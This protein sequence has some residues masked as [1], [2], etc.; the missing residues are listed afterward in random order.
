LIAVYYFLA[1]ILWCVGA[2]FLLAFSFCSKYRR[3]I[4]ARFFLW[5]N[6][7]FSP[8]KIHF[9]ACSF[10]EV[11]SIAPLV[12]I[13]KENAAISV[14]TQTGFDE[15]CKITPNSRFLPFEIFLPFWMRRSKILIIFEAELWPMLVFW[16]RFKGA[17]VILI[18]ARIS[19]RSYGKYLKFSFF[20]REIFK[21]IDK[22]Y[23]QSGTDAKRLTSLGA[24]NVVVNGNIKSAFLPRPSKNYTKPSGRTVVLA[25]THTGE[26]AKILENLDL[27]AEDR[28]LVA[29][30]HPERFNEVA[31]ILQSFAKKRN[32][33]FAKFSLCKNFDA[34]CTLIDAMGE[35]INIYA[36]SDVVVLG[37]SFEPGIGG[38]NPIEAAQF[39]NA[40]ITGK[41]IFNQ[42]ALFN[43]VKGVKFANYGQINDI[44]KNELEI[45]EI[46]GN[47]SADEIIKDIRES[48]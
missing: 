9:H 41:F 31:Q 17:R 18:N 36:I 40:V 4:P 42:K 2:I 33:S 13:F 26:E 44:L 47:S 24:K 32:F 35:L 45:C 16:A 46:A 19:D 27:N 21:F 34:K 10:G 48:L 14:I 37:G 5:K 7:K 30:R 20:Y 28:L 6:P 15:A 3:S 12:D 39:K 43:L 38:H 1:L 22:I 25:S 11:R 29:P 8:L 23:A